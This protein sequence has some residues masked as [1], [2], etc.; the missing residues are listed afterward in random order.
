MFYSFS[1]EEFK[2]RHGYDL[3]EHLPALFGD[4]D[5]ETNK[6]VLC[7]YRETISDLLLE[8]FTNIW[9][10]WAESH[11]AIIRNQEHGSPAAILDL[12][13]ASHIKNTHLD[14]DFQ[15]Q[16]ESIRINL[17]IVEERVTR[18]VENSFWK[19][20]LFSIKSRLL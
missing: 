9:A 5:E 7:D 17:N 18:F 10:D 13:E 4:S 3:K 2:Q 19:K 1:F 16:I 11:N 8:R 6:R 12:Y 15:D 14:S 20:C